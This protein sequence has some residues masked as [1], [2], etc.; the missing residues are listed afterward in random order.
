MTKVTQVGNTYLYKI[1]IPANTGNGATI[2]SLLVT[3][4]WPLPEPIGVKICGQIPAGTD[5]SAIVIA[6]RRIGAAITATDYTTHGQ[7][8]PAG[9]D[10]YEPTD[11]SAVLYVRSASTSTVDA[12]CIV[13][14]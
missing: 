7:Y 8:V 3:A 13:Y 14:N 1:T 5:R 10:W 9:S 2:Q 11:L 12:T 6:S 4:G